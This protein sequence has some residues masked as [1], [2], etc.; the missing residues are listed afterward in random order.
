[1][2]WAKKTNELSKEN[3]CD[4]SSVC[5]TNLTVARSPKFDASKERVGIFVPFIV[6]KSACKQILIERDIALF[7]RHLCKK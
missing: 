6:D 4:G 2:N 7:L 5:A 1:M 3:E